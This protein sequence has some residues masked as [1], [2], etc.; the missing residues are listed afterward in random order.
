MCASVCVRVVEERDRKREA[1]H[2]STVAAKLDGVRAIVTVSGAFV[3]SVPI[4]DSMRRSSLHIAQ[5]RA[6]GYRERQF[7]AKWQ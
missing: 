2:I 6:W 1:H 4:L 3:L 7:K 5:S